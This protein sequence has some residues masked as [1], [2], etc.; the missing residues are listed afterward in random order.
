MMVLS[1]AQVKAGRFTM[2]VSKTK[3][4]EIIRDLPESIDIE[5]LMYRLY[6]LQNIEAGESDSEEGRVLTH[7]EATERLTRKWQS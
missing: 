5:E 3:V 1:E 7:K 4:S 2:N 6:L